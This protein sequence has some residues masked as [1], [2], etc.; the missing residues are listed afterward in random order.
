MSKQTIKTHGI[1]DSLWTI[2]VQEEKNTDKYAEHLLNVPEWAREPED[3]TFY[4]II[5]GQHRTYVNRDLWNEAETKLSYNTAHL[6]DIERCPEEFSPM[7]VEELVKIF[8]EKTNFARS[9]NATAGFLDIFD[10]LNRE[11]KDFEKKYGKNYTQNALVKH[12][13]NLKIIP[14]VDSTEAVGIDSVGVMST[15]WKY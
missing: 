1:D 14:M 5:E 11:V 7:D 9:R 8:Q 15:A 10:L 2:L 3:Y 4:T 6:Y 13:F 12:I